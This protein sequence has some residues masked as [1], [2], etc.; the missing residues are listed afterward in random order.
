MPIRV[1]KEGLSLSLNRE[2][3]NS[4]LR[5]AIY[6]AAAN[7]TVMGKAPDSTI[8]I[9][10]LPPPDTK[11]WTVQRKAEVVAAVRSGRISLDQACC[12]Y[13][14]SIEEF[15]AWQRMVE[16]HGVAGLRVTHAQRSWA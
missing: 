13:M 8:S 14:L 1:L 12:R 2:A 3:Q 6:A 11:R 4:V 5:C 9:D 10:H 16:T 7:V 15:I